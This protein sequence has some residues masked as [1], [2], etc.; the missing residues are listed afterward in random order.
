M[1]L[2]VETEDDVGLT[3][4]GLTKRYGDRIA[5]DDLTMEVPARRVTGFVGPNGA[6][7]TT[8]IRMLL[9]LVRPTAGSAQILG[10]P[11]AEPA[12]YL[13]RVG[14]L[15][16][17]PAFYPH[18]TGRDNLRVLGRLAGRTSRIERVLDVTGL[19]RRAGDPVA[20]Y[21]LGM[22]QRLAIAAALLPSP[23][24]VILD[25]PA[26]GLDPSGIRE[27]R[28]LLRDLADDGTTVLVSS[29]Q[30][31]ELEQ[32][33]DHVVLLHEGRLRFQGALTDLLLRHHARVLARPEDPAQLDAL[34]RIAGDDGW[35]LQVDQG[36]LAGDS[37]RRSPAELNRLAHAH[38]I[39]LAELSSRPPTLEEIFFVLTQGGAER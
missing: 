8:T 4:D 19:S 15:V 18:L 9:G 3:T 14:S 33:C 25:E 36:V 17:G 12:A 6:G 37:P 7:K 5:V 10:H 1:L 24:L 22:R 39:T 16:D 29:H 26:N 2:I 35:Q 32:V 28:R 11:L 34:A 13:R 23:D 31:A 30:L 21:S 38:G 27:I 20:A